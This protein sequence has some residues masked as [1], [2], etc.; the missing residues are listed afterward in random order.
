MVQAPAVPHL[1]TAR[2]LQPGPQTGSPRVP[3]TPPNSPPSTRVRDKAPPAGDARHSLEAQLRRVG[4]DVEGGLLPEIEG[5]L[6]DVG[7]CGG[8]ALM[9][10]LA[11]VED[12]ATVSRSDMRTMAETVRLELNELREA[13]HGLADRIDSLGISA[14][15]ASDVATAVAELS[16]SL[17]E[18]ITPLTERQQ[19][20][21]A[22][23]DRQ[24]AG[25][26]N[27]IDAKADRTELAAAATTAGAATGAAAGAAAGTAC[28]GGVRCAT[29]G[30]SVDA[31]RLARIHDSLIAMH[32]EAMEQKAD[33][34]EL[35]RLE[36][37]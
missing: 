16:S 14:A 33:R 1:P 9:D 37:A 6:I 35:Q 28:E 27:K 30:P 26:I 2:A 8:S 4:S 7:G 5:E 10:R 20:L 29:T 36:K 21:E 25:L 23:L 22:V 13:M 3:F 15:R 19:Q 12:V 17:H 34:V 32:A 18:A 31:D 11:L 24:H